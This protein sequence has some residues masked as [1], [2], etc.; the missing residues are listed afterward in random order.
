[1]AK[2][3]ASRQDEDKEMARLR[4]EVASLR[5]Q[6]SRQG[7]RPD[8]GRGGSA[9]RRTRQRWRTVLASLLIV[10][11]CVLAPLS[12]IAVWTKNLVTNTDRYVRTVAP[13]A[14][15]PAIQHA[16]AD[17]ITAQIFAHVDVQGLYNQAV[18]GLAKQGLRPNAVTQLRTLAGPVTNGSRASPTRKWPRSP[19][20]PLSP[21]PGSGPTARLTPRWTRR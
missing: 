14:R 20:A 3:P 10:I 16:L 8:E 5:S 6:L 9:G 18:D 12:A 1:M 2:E 19:A 21:T 13:L 11:A 15:E 17:K 4:A 7:Q